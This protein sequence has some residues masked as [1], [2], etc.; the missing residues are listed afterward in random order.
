M[1]TF[2]LPFT[3]I[4]SSKENGTY[5]YIDE[6]LCIKDRCLC[7]PLMIYNSERYIND[8]S[9]LVITNVRDNSIVI[10]IPSSSL[11]SS[12]PHELVTDIIRYIYEIHSLKN[13]AYRILASNWEEF[14]DVGCIYVDGRFWTLEIDGDIGYCGRQY[15]DPIYLCSLVAR[16]AGDCRSKTYLVSNITDRVNL[17]ST[18]YPTIPIMM[19]N[20][21]LCGLCYDSCQH[22][23][24]IRN[25]ITRSRKKIS[26]ID[27]FGYKGLDYLLK[28]NEKAK[29]G[30]EIFAD[31]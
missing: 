17:D 21:R 2:P 31:D 3:K 19:N 9:R 4:Y 30:D 12:T 22:C 11:S 13:V 6:R 8:V 29:Y 14:T 1:P 18:F 15:K 25:V 27:V 5:Y 16:L 26:E 23:L 24:A 20:C 28:G 7:N 10:D